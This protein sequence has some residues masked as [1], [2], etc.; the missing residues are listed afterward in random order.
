MSILDAQLPSEWTWKQVADLYWI[1]KKPRN[2]HFADHEAIPFVPMELVPTNGKEYVS[3]EMRAPAQI[4]SGTYFEKGD[5]LLSKIT[6]SFENGKQGLANS[7]AVPF[8]VAS[9]EV[10]PLQRL[11]PEV[12]SRLL[13]YYLLHPEV[14]ESIAG[15]MEGSTGRQRVPER[16]VLEYPVPNP[17]KEEQDKIAAVLWKIQR[18]IEVEEK[19]TATARE[20]K[21]AAM[22]QL[23][24]RGLR[25]EAQQETEI[26][27]IPESWEVVQ[28]GSCA[29]IG[30]GTT[31]N[32]QHAA[33]W[34]GGNIPWITSGRMYERRIS[35]S[36]T[37]VTQT[38]LDEC[39]LPLLQPGAILMA[40]VGQGKTLGH[41]A[42]LDSV[43]T[44]S[45][46][47]GFIQL[48]DKNISPEFVRYYLEGQYEYLRQLA[49]GN[50]ST[51]AALTSAILRSFS[52][53]LPKPQEQNEIVAILNATVSKISL[54]ERKQA[55]L[56]DLFKTMLHQLMTGEIRVADLEIDTSEVTA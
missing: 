46:H 28:L 31:P 1:T 44:V 50:G 27:S 49:A 11:T 10:I 36:E 52:I 7:I 24:T 54:H 39:S 42:V 23:F 14:R 55:A 8:G 9:T 35:G 43:A 13:F 56:Q 32:R 37:H 40:I 38:A 2:I 30:N 12:N 47:V 22:R 5:I 16:V 4:A 45:R 21:Q 15:K 19:L 29:R 18:A 25:G 51:R 33:Y 20:L 6:P 34:Q 41:C 53:P 17:P 26:G 3:F 48:H